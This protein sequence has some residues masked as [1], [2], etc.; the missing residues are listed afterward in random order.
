MAI[1]VLPTG[2]PPQPPRVH[3]R[4]GLHPVRA[5]RGQ[6]RRAGR[7]R[8]DH[9][10]AGRGWRL[11]VARRLLHPDRPAA[12]QPQ[13]ARGAHQG[14]GARTR[15]VIRRSCC[16]VSTTRWARPRRPSATG[17]AARPRC[18]TSAR[19]MPR[20]SSGHCPARP[21]CPS[22]SACAGRRSCSGCTSGASDGRGGRAGRSVRHVY[23]GDLRDESL[24]A[25]RVV[26]GG[27]VTGMRTV[28][29][30][31]Q[32]T[33]A[34]ATVED[35]QGSIEVVVFPRL[36]ETSRPT[37]RDGAILLIA[38]RVDHKGEEVSLL[39]DLVTDWDDA[40]AKGP[41]AF[42]RDVAAGDR[43]RGGQRR[44]PVAVGL[45]PAARRSPCRPRPP[46]ARRR[47]RTTRGRRRSAAR[48]AATDHA[49]RTDPDVSRRPLGHGHRRRARRARG[50]R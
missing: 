22:A 27:I 40:V 39:A 5:A 38:G 35:L 37:W 14:R 32:E 1:E 26:V 3:R 15:S 30:K 34:I 46:A 25:Q 43:G 24:D 44:Q 36:F 8:V 9:R 21:R 18:S 11:P 41:D 28:I 10:G 16:S 31:R 17:S 2:R 45:D 23:S 12:G 20:P 6:E 4:G 48:R 49:G 13:G 7:H 47:V 50:A 33:M 42:A 29:T 19:P